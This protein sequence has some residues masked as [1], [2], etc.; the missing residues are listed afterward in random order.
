MN[1]PS[2]VEA[3]RE[4]EAARG[5]IHLDNVYRAMVQAGAITLTDRQ[6]EAD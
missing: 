2:V 1:A 5:W 6:K 3:L 4:C